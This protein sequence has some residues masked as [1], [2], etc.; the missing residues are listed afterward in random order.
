MK[1]VGWS[2]QA[3]WEDGTKYDITLRVPMRLGADIENFLDRVEEEDA[4]DYMK[5]E[6]E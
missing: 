4:S 2:L 1:L 5:Q 3:L 6:D